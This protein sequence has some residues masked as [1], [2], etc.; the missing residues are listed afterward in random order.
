MKNNEKKSMQQFITFKLAGK[1]YGIPIL[2]VRE[3]NKVNNIT[4]IP[5]AENYIEGITNLRGEIVP[6]VN[7]RK[8]FGIFEECNNKKRK[9]IIIDYLGSPV[10]LLV[11]GISEVIKIDED[12]IESESI[13]FKEIGTEFIAG[14]GKLDKSIMPILDINKIINR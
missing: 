3:I 12:N 6:V 7:V 2:Y 9:L 11:D 8:R 1:T 4:K 10:G 13:D 5:N 14:L